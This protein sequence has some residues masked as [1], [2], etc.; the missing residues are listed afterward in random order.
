MGGPG[1]SANPRG[2]ESEPLEPS[3]GARQT[4]WNTLEAS[5]RVWVMVWLMEPAKARFSGE[6]SLSPYLTLG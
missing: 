3:S 4:R 6:F 5:L 1:R 2:A